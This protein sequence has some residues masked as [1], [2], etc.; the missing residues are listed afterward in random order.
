MLQFFTTKQIFL[1]ITF[2]Q[3]QKTLTHSIDHNLLC[4][5]VSIKTEQAYAKS[6][7]QFKKKE[8]VIL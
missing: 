2:H 5:S 3:P 4:L 6:V 8:M 7:T 1:N